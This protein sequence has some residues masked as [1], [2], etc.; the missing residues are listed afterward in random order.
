MKKNS[1]DIRFFFSKVSKSPKSPK[2]ST[3]E[4]DSA[5]SGGTDIQITSISASASVN[6]EGK[7]HFI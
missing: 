3:N 7:G 2:Q 4:S 6:I 5:N 1:S